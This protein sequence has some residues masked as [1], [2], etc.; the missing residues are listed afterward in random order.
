M[1]RHLFYLRKTRCLLI[2]LSSAVFLLSCQNSS[3][4]DQHQE[5]KTD[6][7][8]LW[9][10]HS[11]NDQHWTDAL[12]IG[13]GHLGAMIFGGVD[14][15][16]IQFNESSLWTGRPRDYAHPGAFKYLG[17]IRRLI[18]A[19]RQ[20]Q[21]EQ[22]AEAHFMGIKDHD[23]KAYVRLREEWLKKVRRDTAAAAENYDD[24]TWPLMQLPIINGWEAGG[25][26]GLDGALWFRV[27]FEVPARWAGQDL[28]VD[29]GRI[30]DQDYCYV[31]GH[32]VA[33]GAGISTK[34]H[35]LLKAKDLHAGE[36]VLAIQVINFFDK[37]G[38]TGVKNDRPIF[39][40]YPANAT[41]K[42]AEPLTR[43]W[44]YWVQNDAP[45]AYPQYEASYQ[46][47]GD[48]YIKDADSASQQLPVSHY[49]RSLNLRDATVNVSYQKGGVK[50]SRSYFT[51]AADPVMVFKMKAN[52][53]G[54]ISF[55]A[56]FSTLH[57]AHQYFKID[58]QT[59]GMRLQVKDGV[60]KGYSALRV[61]ANGT[62]AKVTVTDSS[63]EVSQADSA[64]LYTV[65]ATNFVNAKDVSNKPDSLCK[66]YL[67]QIAMVGSNGENKKSGGERSSS[68][69][70]TSNSRK[71]G[72]YSLLYKRHETAYHQLFDRFDLHLGPVGNEGTG[73]APMLPTDQRIK[74][75]SIKTDPGLITLYTQY[76]R[77]LMISATP[78]AG[79][80]ANLQ[81]IWN[82]LL[83]PPWGSKYT[84]NI[85]LEMNYWPAETLN[86]TACT[87]PLFKLIEEVAKTGS[88]TAKQQYGAPG[89]I[90][91][92]NTDIWGAT[93]P[94]DAAK[95]GIWQGGAAWLCHHLWEHF[96]FTM[97]SVFLRDTAYPMMKQAAMFYAHNLV[98][99]PKT[100]YLV[101]VP[102]NSP[103]HGGLVAGP[104]MDHQLIR[105]LFS[106][107]I[108]AATILK[109]DRD[110]A[111]E[112]AEKY[113]QIAPNQIGRY[114]QLQ[115]WMQDIDDTAD[116]HRHVSHLWGVY[117]GNDISW[118]KDSAMMRAARQSLIY[119]GDAGTGWSV[120]WKLNLWARFKDGN[121]ALKLL[122]ELLRPAE[123]AAGR[124]RGG[125]YRNMMDAHPPFQ[126]D[127]NFGGAA[128]L[129]EMLVQSQNGYI[130][131]LP[132]LPDSL[133]EGWVKGIRA[134]GGYELRLT[135]KH[136]QLQKVRI[137]GIK[138]GICKVRYGKLQ[139]QL[140][141]TAGEW[142]TL[143]G[144]LRP[145]RADESGRAVK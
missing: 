92:H 110:F 132:A 143:D 76:A 95:H 129:A 67:Y 30:R 10:N 64:V 62:R 63:L 117:P 52:Q 105:D 145:V 85:N 23:P 69:R 141:V 26:Q 135:W 123:G 81:G 33:S 90:L 111:K 16:H 91:H 118:D 54:K 5:G 55:K 130:D 11:A 93:A 59:L 6:D 77:Y 104:T 1:T 41:P 84:T 31:N 75:F 126:I 86:L 120:A 49:R 78:P 94:I 113:K 7:L 138:S 40:L 21:A 87:S 17:Q 80:A 43:T 121:H 112:L 39:V 101:S 14:T 35:Y 83:T 114:G 46:P 72:D 96:L 73:Q 119:R 38:F 56:R 133:S 50:Y 65:T 27:R 142:Y 139:K 44:K 8:V 122:K 140:Q 29:L 74:N 58:S 97:D 70:K 88:I 60:L 4:K 98:K 108:R 9:Y 37:G 68:L 24:R 71:W 48:I 2:I 32:F 25:H 42:E 79:R 34:R 12:P 3:Q 131:L 61:K 136:H 128:G 137:N 115:E 45:P 116:T 22:L 106:N 102:S 107:C 53:P 51:S 36:N 99:D 20:K 28:Y 89:W 18:F 82:N 109:T 103:E 66:A 15:D 127:G 57:K 47:F 100:G 124:E 134:R 144:D 125:V 13:N 19:G